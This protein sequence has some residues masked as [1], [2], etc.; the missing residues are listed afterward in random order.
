M[1]IYADPRYFRIPFLQDAAGGSSE[2]LRL[3]APY[4]H[5]GFCADAS[6]RSLGV[7]VLASACGGNPSP[8]A[9]PT[10]PTSTSGGPPVAV[11]TGDLSG[12]IENLDTVADLITYNQSANVG[13]LRTRGGSD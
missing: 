9:S 8:G 5:G 7:V 12:R 10:A 13:P 3:R 6:V 1:V 2:R 4:V 11:P